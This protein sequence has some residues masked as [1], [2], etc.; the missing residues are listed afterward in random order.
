MRL[1]KDF[2]GAVL[3][4][5]GQ[6]YVFDF[7]EYE[8]KDFKNKKIKDEMPLDDLAVI[9]MALRK[10]TKIATYLREELKYDD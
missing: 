5:D 10:M 7:R 8:I 2:Y 1:P 3:K 9:Q 4:I 6:D